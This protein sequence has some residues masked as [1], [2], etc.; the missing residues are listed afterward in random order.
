MA[1]FSSVLSAF[2]SGVAV[3]RCQKVPN[4]QCLKLHRIHGQS[5]LVMKMSLFVSLSTMMGLAT[6]KKTKQNKTEKNFNREFQIL[7]WKTFES[8]FS[9]KYEN[10]VLQ[11]EL[12]LFIIFFYMSEIPKVQI[13]LHQKTLLLFK[14]KFCNNKYMPLIKPCTTT[15]W[16]CYMLFRSVSLLFFPR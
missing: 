5:L 7:L 9:T 2:S 10:G 11:E 1:R 12:Q 3:A 8:P 13:I 6:I 14:Q 16:K 15:L 4:S